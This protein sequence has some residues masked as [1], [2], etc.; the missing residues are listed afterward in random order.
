MSTKIS[1][2]HY[3]NEAPLGD[4]KKWPT[5][6]VIHLCNLLRTIVLTGSCRHGASKLAQSPA[7]CR[8][9]R[10][11][12]GEADAARQRVWQELSNQT[13]CGTPA[14]TPLGAFAVGPPRR[15]SSRKVVNEF[16]PPRPPAGLTGARVPE[17]GSLSTYRWPALQ[18]RSGL[19]SI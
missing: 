15:E 12:L 6:A 19:L 14:R 11:Y 7:A 10:L 2:T 1:R 4:W 16:E 9:S 17:D 8:L 13:S 3:G 5:E 18:N